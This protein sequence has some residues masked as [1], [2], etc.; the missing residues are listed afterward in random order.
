MED[1]MSDKAKELQKAYLREWRRKN[2]ARI[3]AYHAKW[4]R[5]NKEKIREY[6]RQYWEQ[7]AKMAAGTPPPPEN[8]TG[9]AGSVTD[10]SSVTD[11]ANV[12]DGKCI[13]C[14]VDLQGLKSNAK[15]CSPACRQKHYRKRRR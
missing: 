7:K 13:V 15:Y 5:K 12:T 2:K 3:R 14:G 6:R 11:S 4:R 9:Q 10:S 8:E 1:K